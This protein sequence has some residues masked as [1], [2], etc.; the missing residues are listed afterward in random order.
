VERPLGTAMQN[1]LGKPVSHIYIFFFQFFVTNFDCPA[2]SYKGA[3]T[4]EDLK[5]PTR[6]ESDLRVSNCYTVK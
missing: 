4:G 3:L 2:K 5:M 1:Q 6:E